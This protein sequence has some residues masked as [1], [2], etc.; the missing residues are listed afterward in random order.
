M[1]EEAEP[2]DV[3]EQ[4]PDT[5]P[6]D[7][8]GLLDLVG[9]GEALDGLQ[10]DGEAERRQ[11][12]GVD[13]GAHHLGPHP[14]EGVL[15]GG[16]GALGETDGHQ[17]HHQGHHVREHVEGVRQHGQRLRQP[18][19]HHFHHEEEEGQRQHLKN[20]FPIHFYMET[21]LVAKSCPTHRDP[22]DNISPGLP[23]LHHLPESTQAHTHCSSD[24]IQP[25]HPLPS[26]SFAVNHSQH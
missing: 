21:L 5:D 15:L 23:V 17:G 11:E 22:I 1:V 13:Q 4:P 19:H 26:P 12:D 2:Q 6:D 18:A 3:D 10:Q 16:A 14:A 7:Y 8:P 9:L 24:S 25:P 20:K